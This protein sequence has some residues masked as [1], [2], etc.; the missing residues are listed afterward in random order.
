MRGAVDRRLAHLAGVYS[1]MF[2]GVAL[3]TALSCGLVAIEPPSPDPNLLST[4]VPFLVI[5]FAM[6]TLAGVALGHVHAKQAW[7]RVEGQRLARARESLLPA[8]HNVTILRALAFGVPG[9]VGNAA[10]MLL[11]DWTIALIPVGCVG[12]MALVFPSGLHFDRFVRGAKPRAEPAR[13]TAGA[14]PARAAAAG[15]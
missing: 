1:V 15:A 11:G 4:M 12:M 10:L 3:M 8:F 9:V 13:T 14:G 2:G 6:T 5:V 7:L